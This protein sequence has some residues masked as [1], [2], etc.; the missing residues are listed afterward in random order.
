MSPP[1]LHDVDTRAHRLLEQVLGILYVLRAAIIGLFNRVQEMRHWRPSY[2]FLE[3]AITAEKTPIEVLD[4]QPGE[5][6]QV[7]SKEEIMATLDKQNRN[8]GLLF[9]GGCLAFCGGI[10]RVLRRVYRI[11]DEKS[12]R[13]LGMKYALHHTGGGHL[14][15]GLPSPLPQGQLSTI[16]GK[17]ASACDRRDGHAPRA[18]RLPRPAKNLEGCPIAAIKSDASD[19]PGQML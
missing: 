4:L 2:P 3:G 10:Y 5:L 16:E 19:N 12:G 11:V 9:D 15:L 17:L 14:P 18:N 6:V 7:R 13:M 1:A 8:R